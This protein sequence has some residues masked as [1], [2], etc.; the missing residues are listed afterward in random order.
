MFDTPTMPEM[1]VSMPITQSAD[2]QQYIGNRVVVHL[3]PEDDAYDGEEHESDVEPVS[4]YEHIALVCIL[5]SSVVATIWA[6]GIAGLWLRLRR[7][8]ALALW[9]RLCGF[10]ALWDVCCV[11]IFCLI[12]IL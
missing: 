6:H 8:M 7:L 4:G 1:S 12:H 3:C 9:L 5:Q 2:D 11:V 10:L